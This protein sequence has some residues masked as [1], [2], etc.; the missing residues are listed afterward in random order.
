MTKRLLYVAGVIL[1]VM[2][3]ITFQW[4]YG[5]LAFVVL[6]VIA[7]GVEGTFAPRQRSGR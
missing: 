4:Y 5:V 6:V 2:F 7:P 1:G 3:W